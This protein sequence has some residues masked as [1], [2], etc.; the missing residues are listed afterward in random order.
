MERLGFIASVFCALFTIFLIAWCGYTGY[1]ADWVYGVLAVFWSLIM[2]MRL[3]ALTSSSSAT[4]E[5]SVS[6]V[7][8]AQKI[9]SSLYEQREETRQRTLEYSFGGSFSLFLASGFAFVFWLAYCAAFPFD[10]AAITAFKSAAGDAAAGALAWAQIHAFDWGRILLV[11]MT[12]FMTGF[13]MRSF[14]HDKAALR[15][16]MLVFACYAFSGLIF[17]AGLEDGG[18]GFALAGTGFSGNGAGMAALLLGTIA[19]GD[20]LSLFDILLL[21]GGTAGLALVAFALFIPLGCISLSAQNASADRLIVSAGILCGLCLI[22]SIF[23]PFTPALGA[24]QW[25]CCVAV[26]MAWGH[27]ERT[28]ITR[29]A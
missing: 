14:A 25:M 18:R 6:H 12:L 22:L 10:A 21:E 13:V 26:F 7:G 16:G 23:L 17:F 8:L 24:Y 27:S 28:L 2:M 4:A 3:L 19:Q 15:S 29:P 20:T 5:P 11:T 9:I 1:A